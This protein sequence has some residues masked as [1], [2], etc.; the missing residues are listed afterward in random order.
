MTEDQRERE[1][2]IDR[3]TL[4]KRSGPQKISSCLRPKERYRG[5]NGNLRI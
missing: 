3:V 2:K 4:L 5:Q 1:V